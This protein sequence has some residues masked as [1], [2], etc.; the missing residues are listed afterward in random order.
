MAP[1]KITAESRLSGMRKR[2]IYAD[3]DMTINLAACS[4]IEGSADGPQ[5]ADGA[6]RHAVR[7]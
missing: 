7:V 6:A 1:R 5:A 2:A 4:S 3:G